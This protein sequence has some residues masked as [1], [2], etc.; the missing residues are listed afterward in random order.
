MVLLELK[1]RGLVGCNGECQSVIF[2]GVMVAD[3][4]QI[5]DEE[6]VVSEIISL[7]PFLLP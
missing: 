5:L 3:A 4:E 7:S 2:V 6:H 1:K